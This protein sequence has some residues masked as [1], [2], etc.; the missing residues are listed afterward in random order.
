MPNKEEE[1]FVEDRRRFLQT[2]GR[3]AIVTP[4]TITLLLASGQQNFAVA[5]SGMSGGG[6]LSGGIT[7]T[8]PRDDDLIQQNG[9][10]KPGDTICIPSWGCKSVSEPPH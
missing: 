1:A 9:G 8:V 4:P 10:V 2:C 5:G 7:Y 6:S 3:F